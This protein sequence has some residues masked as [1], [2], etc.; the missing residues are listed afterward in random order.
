MHDGLIF[1]IARTDEWSDDEG[2]SSWT[3]CSVLKLPSAHSCT[4]LMQM[5]TS[6]PAPCSVSAGAADEANSHRGL[7]RNHQDL[8]GAVRDSGALQQGA[9]GA[10]P[11]GGQRKRDSKVNLLWSAKNKLSRKA[12]MQWRT[13]SSLVLSHQDPEQL[14][15]SQVPSEG[16]SRQQVQAGAGPEGAGVRQ[17]GDRQEDEQPQ[18]G[19]HA[20]T[21]DQRPVPYV[22]HVQSAFPLDQHGTAQLG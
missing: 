5:M 12:V 21:Q 6:G 19:S 20:A 7:Q 14:W 1:N 10:I 3:P 15:A 22:S 9:T 8:R 4:H 17:Q 13:S 2:L 11:A 16:D 18:T